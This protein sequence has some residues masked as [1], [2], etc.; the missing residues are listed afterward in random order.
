MVRIN[1]LTWMRRWVLCIQEVLTKLTR[2]TCYQHSYP[3]Q[4]NKQTNP[5]LWTHNTKTGYKLFHWT[6]RPA[7][8]FQHTTQKLGTWYAT[9]IH[10]HSSEVWHLHPF[11]TPLHSHG[12]AQLIEI[13]TN[14]SFIH[15]FFF[16]KKP[17]HQQ[18]TAIWR[19]DHGHQDRLKGSSHLSHFHIAPGP[20][21]SQT[22]W[23]S[24]I[25]WV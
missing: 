18:Q 12:V 16:F 24:V 19:V 4:M 1:I 9:H 17:H 14:F 5:C 3:F 2:L 8:V 15:L 25:T 21:D 20:G 23:A 7:H 13:A 6:N 10:T 11:T 22:L